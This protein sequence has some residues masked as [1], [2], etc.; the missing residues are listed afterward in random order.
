MFWP[1]DLDEGETYRGDYD[2][3]EF[4]SRRGL[5][6]AASGPLADSILPCLQEL[7]AKYGTDLAISTTRATLLIDPGS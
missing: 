7:S 2:D 4:L 5:A 3:L 1:L 6:E